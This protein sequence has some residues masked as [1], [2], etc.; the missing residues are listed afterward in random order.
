MY[1]QRSAPDI[2]IYDQSFVVIPIGY[3]TR[4]CAVYVVGRIPEGMPLIYSYT[5]IAAAHHSLSIL[6]AHI[7]QAQWPFATSIYSKY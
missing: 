4:M 3:T 6:F 7:R 1:G 2:I 5:T